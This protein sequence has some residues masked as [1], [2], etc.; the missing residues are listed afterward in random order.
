LPEGELL[1][2]WALPFVD[3]D[4]DDLITISSHYFKR[5]QRRI[6][7]SLSGWQQADC[8]EEVRSVDRSPKDLGLAR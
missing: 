7:V 1:L 2:I 3:S 4:F 6:I 8:F 5:K